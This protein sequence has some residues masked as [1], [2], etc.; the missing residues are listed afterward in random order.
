MLTHWGVVLYVHRMYRFSACDS[1]VTEVFP[2]LDF[3]LVLSTNAAI[4]LRDDS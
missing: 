4:E 2:S 1:L 3:V